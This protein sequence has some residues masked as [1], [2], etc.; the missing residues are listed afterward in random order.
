MNSTNRSINILEIVIPTILLVIGIYNGF[1]QSMY[2]AGVFQRAEVFGVDYYQGLTLHGV[3]NAVVLTTFFAVALGNII[4][5]DQLQKTLNSK[6]NMLSFMLMLIGTLAAAIPMLMGDAS[7]LYTFYAP[8]KAHTA[9]Y[10]GAVLLVI[11]SWVAFFNWFKPY[12]SWKKENPDKKVPLGVVGMMATFIV[13]FLCTIPV[14]VEII[15]LLIPWSLGLVDG[16]N[17]LL[18]RTLFWFF[19]HALVYFWLLPVYV[20]IYVFLPKVAGGKLY[21]DLAG[22]IVFF[23]FIIFSIPIGVH[24]Q[25]T[26]PGI[27]RDY[28]FFQA[29]LTMFVAVPSFMTAFT[30]CAS[31][32]YAGIKRGAK[33]IMGWLKTL[34]Y[35][36]KDRYVFAYLISGLIIFIFGG[37]TGLVNASYNMNLVVHNTAFIPGHFHLTI[38]GIVFLGILA[39]NLLMLSKAKGHELSS[40]LN[41]Y[42]PYLWM[43]GLIFLSGGMMFGGIL[44]EPRRTNLGMTYLNPDSDLY[45]PAWVITTTMTAVGGTI[46]T[47]S[48]IC[49]FIVFGK[50]LAKR[51]N[52]ETVIKLPYAS[53]Y[54]DEKVPALFKTF[55]PWFAMAVLLITIAYFGPI[56]EAIDN[57]KKEAPPFEHD[58]PVPLKIESPL[59]PNTIKIEAV[60]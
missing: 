44:G 49:Y 54:H 13:W 57:T 3:I 42:V 8:L 12:L 9:F 58:N 10:V 52:R 60:E 15:V 55:K 17:V 53:A 21:S 25:F 36:D 43:L 6:V 34:P 2:R 45:Q 35:F 1:M 11:G 40:R 38:G 4:V 7:V 27:S 39:G 20:M 56:M 32:E 29:I 33:G 28:K 50:L 47:I 41:L 51:S 14:A 18:T 16:V 5:S 19:G 31:L 26:E 24:H 30:I 48:M 46:M 59:K 37:A 22:R 23:L